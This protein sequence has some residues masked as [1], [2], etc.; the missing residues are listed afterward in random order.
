MSA[1]LHDFPVP[2]EFHF[3]RVE[4]LVADL[5]RILNREKLVDAV[6]R[7]RSVRIARRDAETIERVSL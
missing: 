5:Q 7:R 3:R 2:M 6:R 4:R 1:T